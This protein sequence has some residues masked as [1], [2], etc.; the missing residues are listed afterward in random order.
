MAMPQWLWRGSQPASRAIIRGA[1]FAPLLAAIP[2]FVFFS[3]KLIG[4]FSDKGGLAGASALYIVGSVGISYAVT[5]TFGLTTFIFLARFR[6]AGLLPLMISSLLPALAF[7]S[8]SLGSKAG[9]TKFII[10][11]SLV[12]GLI[13]SGGF[14]RI[15]QRGAV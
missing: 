4:G 11:A 5:L 3:V 7:W 8:Y 14:W 10:E 12:C 13:V 1:I 2:G 9:D 6:C 15:A